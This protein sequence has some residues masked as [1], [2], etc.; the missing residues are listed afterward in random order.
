MNRWNLVAWC[1]V[2]GLS[3]SALLAS[4]RAA[5]VAR[6]TARVARLHL[7]A[8]TEHASELVRLRAGAPP[9]HKPGSGLASR[10]S[11][12]LARCGLPPSALSSLSPES[13]VG[14][15]PSRRQRAVLAL[16]GV[17][18]PQLGSFLNAWRSAEPDWVVSS[19]E[20]SPQMGAPVTPGADLPLRAV[21]GIE[22]VYVERVAVSW[23][24]QPG[25]ER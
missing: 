6:N 18:L 16:G 20:L 17:T 11:A 9:E 3:A 22:A 23:A 8:V 15:G 19:I 7:A 5:W 24:T 1:A 12:A 25:G 14:E 4:G 2:L 13:A 10:V 21:I